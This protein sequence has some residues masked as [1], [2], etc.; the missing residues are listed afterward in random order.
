[1]DIKTKRAW[2]LLLV[3]SIAFVAFHCLVVMPSHENISFREILDLVWIM[4][5]FMGFIY[6]TFESIYRAIKEWHE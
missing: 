2:A 6:F 4:W 5:L 1:M 3:T